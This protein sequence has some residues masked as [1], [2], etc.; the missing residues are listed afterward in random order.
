MSKLSC[1]PKLHICG[2]F[3]QAWSTSEYVIKLPYSVTGSCIV[4]KPFVSRT[5]YR[6]LLQIK[7]PPL[8]AYYTWLQVGV[9]CVFLPCPVQVLVFWPQLSGT[10]TCIVTFP[11]RYEY[12]YSCEFSPVRY[13]YSYFDLYC[14]VRVLVFWPFL[15][16]TSNR[17]PVRYE[18]SLSY[19]VR[20]LLFMW[21]PPLSGTSTRISAFPVR[22]EYSYFDLSCLVQGIVFRPS[23]RKTCTKGG[24]NRAPTHTTTNVYQNWLQ[25]SS[26]QFYWKRVPKLA[27]LGLRHVQRETWT[28]TGL[29]GATTH[30]TWNLYKMWPQSSSD[31]FYAKL[32]PTVASFKL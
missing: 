31:P 25:S 3:V 15:S 24:L 14:P 28:E 13:Q 12:S 5:C 8:F 18:Y 2:K 29:S 17:F 6:Y 32:V 9:A 16:G 30:S 20:V 11:V 7:G 21:F 22:Y 1:V 27:S 10:S 19:P 26:D 23:L 4:G